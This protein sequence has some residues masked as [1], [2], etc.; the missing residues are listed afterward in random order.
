MKH[1]LHH[2]FLALMLLPFPVANIL[3]IRQILA[4]GGSIAGPVFYLLAWAALMLVLFGLAREPDQAAQ[5][6]ALQVG[7]R[8][9]SIRYAIEALRRHLYRD[10][11]QHQ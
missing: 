2:L 1:I 11:H 8:T 5:D 4:E 10:D 9:Q 3:E 6:Q 7:K